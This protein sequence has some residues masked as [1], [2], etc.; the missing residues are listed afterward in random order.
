MVLNHVLMNICY[1]YQIYCHGSLSPLV[2]I[3]AAAGIR[4]KKKNYIK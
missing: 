2:L 3:L 4:L 1:I